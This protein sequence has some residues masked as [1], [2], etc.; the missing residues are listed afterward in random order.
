MTSTP[1]YISHL[2]P[3]PVF[4]QQQYSLASRD[5]EL[6]PFQVCKLNGIGV[7]PW[8]PLKGSASL[9]TSIIIDR[10]YTVLFSALGQT[11][12]AH[13][14]CDSVCVCACVCVRACVRVCVCVCVCL[15]VCV[16]ACVRERAYGR[17][18]VRECLCVCV[19]ARARARVRACVRA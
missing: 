12:C 8:S 4:W 15:C 17:A 11:H 9:F 6:E 5:S 7:L 1:I 13:V 16:C 18:S 10:F 14:V 3:P 2:L 19:C